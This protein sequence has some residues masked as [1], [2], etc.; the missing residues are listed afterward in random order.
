MA[1]MLTDVSAVVVER[2]AAFHPAPAVFDL[3]EF[4]DWPKGVF[5]ALLKEKCLVPAPRATSTVC[6]GCEWQ[7]TKRVAV[8]QV[9]NSGAL[10]AFIVCDEDRDYGRIKIE[11]ERLAR[12]QTT[13]ELF[14][15]Y[16][17]KSLAT[18]PF[19]SAK[20]GTAFELGEFQGRFGA[21]LLRISILDGRAIIE[22][23][24]QIVS[25]AEVLTVS[26]TDLVV[27]LPVLRRVA[28]RKQTDARGTSGYVPDRSKQQ[29]RSKIRASRDLAL[30]RQAILLRKRSGE[31]W[32]RISAQLAKTPAAT[33]GGGNPL[34]V[35]TVRR[36]I[37][38]MDRAERE[39]SRPSRSTRKPRIR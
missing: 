37:V 33:A 25:L 28:N 29:A 9:S 11:P 15:R 19:R 39:K 7:C 23:G 36:I 13:L 35:G 10:K 30:Y 21:R 17:A 26:G 18:G 16:L 4:E 5:E 24:Q 27:Q 12:F 32:P 31:S 6:P 8:R 22:V 38:T 1:S 3:S 20:S 14:S 34:S 2:M